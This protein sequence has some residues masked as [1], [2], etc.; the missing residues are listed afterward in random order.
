MINDQPVNHHSS[1][2]CLVVELDK[3]M[4]WENHIDSICTKVGPGNR[5]I[6]VIKPFVAKETL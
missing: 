5:I 4:N 1:F 3:L 2:R 6:K